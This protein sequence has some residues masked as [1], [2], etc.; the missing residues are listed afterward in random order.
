MSRRE[1]YIDPIPAVPG[2][3]PS[4]VH[5]VNIGCQDELVLVEVV[6]ITF[7]RRRSD[8]NQLRA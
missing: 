1:M 2:P 7:L 4:V 3:V 8:E 5:H 6:V